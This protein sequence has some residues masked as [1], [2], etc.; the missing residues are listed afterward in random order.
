MFTNAVKVA[1]AVY[2]YSVDSE[3]NQL[4]RGAGTKVL[5]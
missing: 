3:E 5:P 2:N 4:N 1:G